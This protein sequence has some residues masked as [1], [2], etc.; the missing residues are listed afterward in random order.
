MLIN[1][2]A[3][4]CEWRKTVNQAYLDDC[5]RKIEACVSELPSGS[6][7][8]GAKILVSRSGKYKVEISFYYHHMNENGYYDGIDG[9]RIV[10]KPCLTDAGFDIKIYGPNKNDIKD[11]LYDVFVEAL[12]Q[13]D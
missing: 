2:I 13:E 6:G 8:H 4:Y 11:Y 12:T 9:Y 3:Q 7:I 10:I 5:E 1:K